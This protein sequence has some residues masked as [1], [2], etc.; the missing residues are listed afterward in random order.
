MLK[1]MT[2]FVLEPSVN[3]FSGGGRGGDMRSPGPAT[4]TIPT[5]KQAPAAPPPFPNITHCP[6]VSALPPLR[7]SVNL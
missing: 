1:R 3:S 6:P 5:H 2:E 7:I 4:S